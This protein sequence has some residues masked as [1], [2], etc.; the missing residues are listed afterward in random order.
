[1]RSRQEDLFIEFIEAA[2]KLGKPLIIHARKAFKEA[3]DVLESQGARKVIMHFFSSREQLRR[4][5][6]NDWYITI[7]TTVCRSKKIRKITRDTPVKRIL[8]ETDAPWLDLEGGRNEPIAI[9]KVSEKVAEVKGLPS[10]EVWRQCGRNA[11]EIFKLPIS[12]E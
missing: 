5:V 2:K 4:V 9:K 8:L 3:V 12:I 7:N 11:V 6:D 10:D 1:M